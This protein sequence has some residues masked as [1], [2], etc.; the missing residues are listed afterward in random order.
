MIKYAWL[1]C[2]IPCVLLFFQSF[3]LSQEDI[4]S[5]PN[6][7]Y[8]PVQDD[9]ENENNSLST[10][11]LLQQENQWDEVE[12]IIMGLDEDEY[13]EVFQLSYEE[14]VDHLENMKKNYLT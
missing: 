13:G 4:D 11:Q 2:S 6:Q 14:K 10:D 9:E 12:R 1:F 5:S 7:T 8:P 3:V